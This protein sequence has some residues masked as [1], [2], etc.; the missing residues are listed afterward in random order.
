MNNPD[1][2]YTWIEG[3]HTI[4]VL[5]NKHISFSISYSIEK[6]T[7]LDAI[8]RVDLEESEI[9]KA[10]QYFTRLGKRY[11]EDQLKR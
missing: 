8:A 6:P 10:D 3:S 5:G 7:I 1:C 11:L 4:N 9:L 2:T